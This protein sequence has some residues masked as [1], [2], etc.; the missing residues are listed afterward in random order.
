MAAAPRIRPGPRRHDRMVPGARV[1]V[2][3]GPRG[4]VM[5]MRAAITGATGLVGAR[6]V[7]LLGDEFRFFPL[8]RSNGFDLA[9]PDPT[10]WAKRLPAV[11]AVLHLGAKT[12]VD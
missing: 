10:G 4:S 8:D 2:A 6:I 3:P 12:A 7:K 5:R 11:D 1:L 9:R